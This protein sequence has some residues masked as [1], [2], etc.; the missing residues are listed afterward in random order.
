MSSL[1][2]VVN[3]KSKDKMLEELGITEGDL[4][5]CVAF[6]KHWCETQPH[7]PEIPSQTKIEFCL[8]N[9]ELDI[10]RTKATFDLYYTLRTTMPQVYGRANP[11]TSI[12]QLSVQDCQVVLLPKLLEDKYGVIIFKLQSQSHHEVDA[13][14]WLNLV[15]N[16]YEVVMEEG[17]M[18]DT[19][20]ILDMTNLG[21]KHVFK[22][23]PKFVSDTFYL[24][25]HLLNDKIKV[26]HILN[27][28]SIFQLILNLCKMIIKP[29]IYNKFKFH[30][31]AQ[32][33][34]EYIPKDMLPNDYGGKYISIDALQKL[35]IEKQ[36][37]YRY[38]FDKLDTLKVNESLRPA[39]SKKQGNYNIFENFSKL[40][41]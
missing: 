5:K 39:S 32:S 15:L 7:L 41:K 8:M 18:L 22:I 6:M 1:S 40:F 4:Q 37:E 10:E 14:A 21:M 13:Y 2:F 27:A 17:V 30:H 25:E 23:T 12:M 29:E 35:W 20:L 33:L 26:F 11:N 38:H 31:S 36:K 34:G 3:K 9:N 16:I 24:I 19:V 28:P